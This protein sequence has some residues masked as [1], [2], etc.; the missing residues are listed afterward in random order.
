MFVKI[1]NHRN[2]TVCELVDVN[3]IKSVKVDLLI[4][5]PT[6]PINPDDDVLIDWSY[7]E[8][9]KADIIEKFDHMESDLVSLLLGIDNESDMYHSMSIRGYDIGGVDV[10]AP[11]YRRYRYYLNEVLDYEKK[12]KAFDDMKSLTPVDDSNHVYVV[13]LKSTSTPIYTTKDTFDNLTKILCNQGCES[14]VRNDN[15]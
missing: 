6:P 5:E 8:K 9:L 10:F 2:S 11:S 7:V 4:P 1:V 3:D 12:V 13:L 14:D 15:R